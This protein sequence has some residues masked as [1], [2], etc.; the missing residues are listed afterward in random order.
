MN[1]NGGT[2]QVMDE[3]KKCFD[4]VKNVLILLTLQNPYSVIKQMWIKSFGENFKLHKRQIN[5]T[6]Y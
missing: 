5:F 1:Q 6:I 3:S 2:Y 4:A